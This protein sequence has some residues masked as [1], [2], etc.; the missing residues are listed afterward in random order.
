M[1]AEAEEAGVMG[2]ED[3]R[4]RP[5]HPGGPRKLENKERHDAVRP[6]AGISPPAP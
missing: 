6:P 2:F 5:E 4:A 1:V 3:K